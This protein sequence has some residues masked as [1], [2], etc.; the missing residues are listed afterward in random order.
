M[1]HEVLSIP[2]LIALVV[3]GLGIL[4]WFL[5]DKLEGVT[6]GLRSIRWAAEKS[7]GFEA[8]NSAV[9]SVT[10]SIAE[11]VRRTQTGLLGWN[12]VG[13]VL[14]VIVLFAILILGA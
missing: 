1:L 8:I 10:H 12:V 13:I 6:N 9:V 3:I 7:F 14:T 2:T 11:A 4:L 5:R